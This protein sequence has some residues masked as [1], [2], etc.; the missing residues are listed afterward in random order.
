MPAKA[1]IEDSEP[2]LRSALASGMEV[3]VV[4]QAGQGPLPSGC[5]PVRSLHQA[6]VLL[7]GRLER[8]LACNV[9]PAA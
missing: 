7:A 1:G 3:M 9:Q 5:V 2:G 4:G 8:H 6:R